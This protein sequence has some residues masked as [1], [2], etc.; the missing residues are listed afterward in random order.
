MSYLL[1][2]AKRLDKLIIEGPYNAD[3][4]RAINAT[5]P[6]KDRRFRSGIWHIHVRWY[7]LVLAFA[8][9]HY[10]HFS[11]TTNRQECRPHAPDCED[12]FLAYQNGGPG[13]PTGI[14][15]QLAGAEARSQLFVTADAPVTVVAAAYKA[16]AKI[17]HP[18]AGG[19]PDEF[20]R[21]DAAY[22]E[23]MSGITS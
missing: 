18:D 2:I 15:D 3:F 12:R 20:R 9:V 23:I 11:N 4:A 13:A 5:I 6:G 16:L 21:I 22:K 19:D 8:Q 7:P 1:Y 10:I 14:P 17:H